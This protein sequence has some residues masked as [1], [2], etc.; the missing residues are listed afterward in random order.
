MTPKW[1]IA[2]LNIFHPLLIRVPRMRTDPLFHYAILFLSIA[3]PSDVILRDVYK[4][5]ASE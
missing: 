4:P 3:S 2:D 1:Y 5:A